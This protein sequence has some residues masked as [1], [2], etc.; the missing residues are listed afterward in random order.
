MKNK[1][2]MANK[3]IG[4]LIGAFVL[5]LLAAAFL[6]MVKTAGNSLQTSIGGTT[7]KL[8]GDSGAGIIVPVIAIGCILALLGLLLGYKMGW[9]GKGHK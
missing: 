3:I 4:G 8:F 9:M 7:G 6:P 5:F 2:G 1:K